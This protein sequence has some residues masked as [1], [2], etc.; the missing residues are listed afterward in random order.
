MKVN[1]RRT[2]H[3]A[4]PRTSSPIPQ[5]P[6]GSRLAA[7]WNEAGA[8]RPGASM[9]HLQVSAPPAGV[10]SPLPVPA[11]SRHQL[12]AQTRCRCSSTASALSPSV[13]G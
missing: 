3:A 7:G 9:Q 13:P 10:G 1:K 4:G 2:S 5:G 12:A 11:R 6:S 8:A